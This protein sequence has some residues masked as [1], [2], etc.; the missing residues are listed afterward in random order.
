[1]NLDVKYERA[2]RRN[3]WWG[4]S[5]AIGEIIWN[6]QPPLISLCHKLH[7]LGPALNHL[8]RRE[9]SRTRIKWSTITKSASVCYATCIRSTRTLGIHLIALLQDLNEHSTL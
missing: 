9:S 3:L 4:S 1:M 6:M 7:G 5:G 2:K 8:I